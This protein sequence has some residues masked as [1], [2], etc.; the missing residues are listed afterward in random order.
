MALDQHIDKKLTTLAGL[1]TAGFTVSG[2]TA[3]ITGTLSAA[4]LEDLIRA[5]SLTRSEVIVAAGVVKV[6][7]RV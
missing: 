4:Q 7:P 1:G 3:T 6:Q 5:A 2:A